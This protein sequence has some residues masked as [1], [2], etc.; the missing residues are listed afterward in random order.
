MKLLSKNLDLLKQVDFKP[1][2]PYD[3]K[4]LKKVL[5]DLEVRVKKLEQAQT[6]FPMEYH[7]TN[8]TGGLMSL[9]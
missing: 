6:Y 4:L 1:L 8:E 5:E 3:V 2:N 9:M 7:E